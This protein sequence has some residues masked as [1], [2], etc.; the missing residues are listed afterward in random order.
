MTVVFDK[1]EQISF[2]L[3]I[4]DDG[5]PPVGV[6]W[7]YVTRTDVGLRIETLPLFVKDISVQDVIE[8]EV[9]DEKRVVRWAHIE[10]SKRSVVWVMAYGSYDPGPALQ[11]LRDMGCNTESLK[12]YNYFA[13][14]VPPEISFEKV[15]VVLETLDKASSAVAFPSFRHE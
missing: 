6:E 12:S 5:W 13:V 8:A 3:A 11:S 4:D 9:D 14:D 7:L 1:M 10:K 15:D 2:S